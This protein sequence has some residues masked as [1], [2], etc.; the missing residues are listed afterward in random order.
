MPETWEKHVPDSA[1]TLTAR[2]LEFDK[3]VQQNIPVHIERVTT[4]I[5]G[6]S[7][8]LPTNFQSEIS[9]T[10]EY[11]VSLTYESEPTAESNLYISDKATTGFKVQNTQDEADLI[12][13]VL[14][15]WIP[16]ES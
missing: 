13:L 6:A 11:G 2:P 16:P 9:A 15:F 5:G 3:L 4:S 14:V 8:T 12:V 1:A 10:T 7:V